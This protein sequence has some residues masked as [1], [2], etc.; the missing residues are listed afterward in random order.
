MKA[1]NSSMN[2]YIDE[3]IAK[4]AIKKWY[5]VVG[6]GSLGHAYEECILALHHFLFLLASWLRRC[7]QLSLTMSL[8]HNTSALREA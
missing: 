7:E 8:C 4:W 1:V 3:F 6:T 5:L 2:Q